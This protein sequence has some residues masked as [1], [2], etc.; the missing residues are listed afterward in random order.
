MTKRHLFS[1]NAPANWPIERKKYVWVTRPNPGPHQLKRCLSLNMLLKNVLKYARTSREVKVI[2][3]SGEVLINNKP[4]KDDKFPVGIMDNIEIKKTNEHFMLII[5]EYNK[6][7]LKKINKENSKIKPCKIIN[8]TI[9]K[10]GKTQLNLFDGRNIIVNN[11]DYKVGDTI[12]IDVEKNKIVDHIKLGKGSTIYIMYGKYI[13]YIG[14]LQ[15]VV[16][17]DGMKSNKIVFTKDKEKIETLKDYAFAIPEDL[18]K[19]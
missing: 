13:G 14:Q 9:L 1:L 5:N 10:K 16:L 2:L 19:K 6:Y 18:F 7:E 3:N 11:S 12:L 15:D 17:E 4:V 8:K